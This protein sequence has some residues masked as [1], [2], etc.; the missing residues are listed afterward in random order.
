MWKKIV[1][2]PANKGTVQQTEGVFKNR[3]FKSLRVLYISVFLLMHVCPVDGSRSLVMF[4]SLSAADG[5]ELL[6]VR[7]GLRALLVRK[8]EWG[9]LSFFFF[10]FKLF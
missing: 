5:E 7:E 10:F 8:S 6:D 1:V 9:V 2:P 3:C 4:P